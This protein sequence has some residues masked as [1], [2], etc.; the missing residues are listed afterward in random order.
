MS[1]QGQFFASQL[2][3]VRQACAHHI[4]CIVSRSAGPADPG[5]NK[6]LRKQPGNNSEG[7]LRCTSAET[8]QPQQPQQ[9]IEDGWNLAAQ[10]LA[11]GQWPNEAK[12]SV[13]VE[14]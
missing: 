4:H 11:S 8:Q 13:S 7:R 14:E 10:C 2:R 1:Q 12:A 5:G 6:S 9:T 3:P